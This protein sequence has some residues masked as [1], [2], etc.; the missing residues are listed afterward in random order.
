[1]LQVPA[2]MLCRVWLRK[3]QVLPEAEL[4]QLLSAF[5]ILQVPGAATAELLAGLAA[6]QAYLASWLTLQVLLEAISLRALAWHLMLQVSSE[7]ELFP[8]LVWLPS[9]L[10]QEVALQFLRSTLL[11]QG[12]GVCL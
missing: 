10:I 9:V 12:G 1:M 6:Y 4:F 7:A 11:T 3:D 8:C 5:L 2:D